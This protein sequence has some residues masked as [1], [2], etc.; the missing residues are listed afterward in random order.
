M[1]DQSH[2]QAQ[3]GRRNGVEMKQREAWSGGDVADLFF[4]QLQS[5]G[6]R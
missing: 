5:D 3:A 6:K 4:F 1:T 2:R